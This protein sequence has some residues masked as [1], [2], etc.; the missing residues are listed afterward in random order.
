MSI[1]L[2]AATALISQ[3]C[4]DPKEDIGDH[5]WLKKAQIFEQQLTA[6]V[7]NKQ[8]VCLTLDNKAKRDEA[9]VLARVDATQKTI[10]VN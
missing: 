1:T 9:K 10:T 6:A 3:L 7:K 2:F 5:Y 4:Y 8:A